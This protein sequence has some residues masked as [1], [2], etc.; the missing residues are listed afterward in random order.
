M[1][2]KTQL[3][4]ITK[5][6]IIAGAGSLPKHVLEACKKK[7]IPYHIIGLIHETDMHVFEGDPNLSKFKVYSVSKILAELKEKGVTHVTL[8]GKVKRADLARLLLDI[9]GAKLLAL[10]L[11]AG[12]ADNCI[13]QTIMNFLESEGFKIIAPEVVATEIVLQKGCI[14]KHKPDDA[15]TADIKKGLKILNGVASFDV[16]QSLVIQSGLVL[17]I[18]AAEGTDELIK[19]CGEIQ[20]QS[21]E[22]PILIKIAKPHQDRRAD[23]P[24]VGT[25]TIEMAK[26]YGIRGIAAEAGSALVMDQSHT[27]KLA[28][29]YKIFIVGV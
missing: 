25:E 13:L 4:N 7:G 27:I 11:K 24:C 23:L 10:I 22:G 3:E 6:G 8:A 21:E 26:Q 14:T 29:K 20:Q 16:G 2:P 17:G 19:R 5:L 18:E 1:A 15:A 9:K 12:L 28:D